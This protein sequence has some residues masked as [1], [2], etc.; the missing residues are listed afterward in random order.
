MVII[1]YD[2]AFPIYWHDIIVRALFDKVSQ[3][4]DIDG[5]IITTTCVYIP[6]YDVL[7]SYC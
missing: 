1:I 7:F 2:V 3:Q 6:V 5:V 4:H